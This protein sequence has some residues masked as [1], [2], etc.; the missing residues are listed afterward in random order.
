L[1]ESFIHTLDNKFRGHLSVEIGSY[2]RVECRFDSA[3]GRKLFGTK[4]FAEAKVGLGAV[5]LN[6]YDAHIDIYM[7]K[8]FFAFL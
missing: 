3:D 2:P 8:T 4:L 1:N 6:K 7:Q 5:K